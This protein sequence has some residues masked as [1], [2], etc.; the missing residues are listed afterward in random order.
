LPSLLSLRSLLAD[1]LYFTR[2]ELLSFL[3]SHYQEDPEIVAWAEAADFFAVM[4]MTKENYEA[5]GMRNRDKRLGFHNS[6]YSHFQ[7]GC[8]FY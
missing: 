2:A 1:S 6:F 8:K 4:S 7:I 3:A 5:K